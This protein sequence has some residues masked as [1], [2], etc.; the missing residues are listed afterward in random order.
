MAF[1]GRLDLTVPDILQFLS[2]SKK[3]GKL[4]LSRLG[5]MGEIVFKDG[6]VVYAISDSTRNTLGNILINQKHLTEK[7]LMA[8]L[9]VQHLSP[10]NKRLGAILVEKGVITPAVLQEAIRHQI[11]QV[12]SEFLTWESGFFRFDHAEVQTDDAIM[13]DA[14]DFLAKAGISSEHLLLEGVR[15][16]DE[17]NHVEKPPRPKPEVAPPSPPDL[18]AAARLDEQPV[19][20]KPPRPR[21]EVAPPPPPDLPA[22]PR[23]D[24]R[25]EARK[26]ARATPRGTGTPPPSPDPLVGGWLDEPHEA[27]ESHPASPGGTPPPGP[28]PEATAASKPWIRKGW[29]EQ[30]VSSPPLSS[31]PEPEAPLQEGQS[32]S[33]TDEIMFDSPVAPWFLIMHFAA[34]VV[35]RGI[36]FFA[37]NDGIT[38]HDQFGVDVV[39][40]FGDEGVHNIKIP[41]T[42]P[43]IFSEI[44]NRRK[45]YR[46][47]IGP[48]KWNDYFL[49][50]L[51]GNKPHEAV[52]IPI[53]VAGNVVAI[54]YG[55]D[56]GTGKPLGEVERLEAL[57]GQT[58]LAIEMSLLEKRSE[59]PA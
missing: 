7:A 46:G 53:I 21:P 50:L 18:P 44:S 29:G 31:H 20:E 22:G 1:I 17:R 4:R 25:R 27:E 9:E 15:R 12:L 57:I 36:L 40:E 51:G 23:L 55:D 13:I 16:L 56:A 52:V 59:A 8:A 5:N 32:P 48:G 42:E 30:P 38:G 24:E 11:E 28:D 45:M 19:V 47:K 58:F 26:P 10:D 3:T 6:K 43:S 2:L 34:D 39:T 41:L 37:R 54:F 49:D 14:N 35:G 33:I